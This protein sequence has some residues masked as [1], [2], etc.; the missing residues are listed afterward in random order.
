VNGLDRLISTGTIQ[1]LK[2]MGPSSL[3]L[4]E[5]AAVGLIRRSG[6]V[7][8]DWS[9][10]SKGRNPP[11]APGGGRDGKCPVCQLPRYAG[12]A[13]WESAGPSRKGAYWHKACLDAFTN[14]TRYSVLG[15]YLAA[16]QGWVCPETGL[17]LRVTVERQHPISG[18]PI[19]GHYIIA[20]EV[21]HIDPLWR[22]RAQADQ[23]KWPDV[24]R[25]WGIANL[26]ALTPQGHTIKTKREAAE[27]AAFKRR[28]YAVASLV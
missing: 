11:L 9:I 2:S 8:P 12:G 4:A 21:D 26:Q 14:W 5:R 16:R 24:L 25:F 17:P 1:P 19:V 23:Y 7:V 28:D 15:S 3:I 10:L 20:I 22:I 27:R 6:V 18:E 13:W